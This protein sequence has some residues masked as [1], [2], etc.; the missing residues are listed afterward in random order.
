MVDGKISEVLSK[1]LSSLFPT[2]IIRS[3]EDKLEVYEVEDGYSIGYRMA[4]C[5]M[6]KCDYEIHDCY[7]NLGQCIVYCI[8]NGFV[9]TYIAIPED[10]PHLKRL[11]KILSVINLPIGL[12]TLSPDGQVKV[13]VKPHVP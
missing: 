4:Y 10:Y 9:P 12:I 3:E 11:E 7:R 1:W 13:A 5:V 8:E 6:T 2:S